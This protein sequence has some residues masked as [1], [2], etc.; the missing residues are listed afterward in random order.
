[1]NADIPIHNYMTGDNVTVQMTYITVNVYHKIRGGKG[2]WD[3]VEPGEM[4][5]V[6]KHIGK[7]LKL[8]V[9]SSIKFTLDD[10]TIKLLDLIKPEKNND[11]SRFNIDSSFLK[12]NELGGTDADFEMK[13]HTLS[14]KLEFRAEIHTQWGMYFQHSLCFGSHNSGRQRL[15][16]REVFEPTLPKVLVPFKAPS[17]SGKRMRSADYGDMGMP[18]KMSRMESQ[19]TFSDLRMQF[20]MKS[21]LSALIVCL[22]KGEEPFSWS[23]NSN[24]TMLSVLADQ[25]LLYYPMIV[26]TDHELTSIYYKD[27][28]PVILSNINLSLEI[29]EQILALSLDGINC[30]LPELTAMAHE[31]FNNIKFKVERARRFRSPP[32]MESVFDKPKEA[33]KITN[34]ENWTLGKLDIMKTYLSSR[35]IPERGN[36]QLAVGI[37][38]H[39]TTPPSAPIYI[40]IYRNEDMVSQKLVLMEEFN[41]IYVDHTES[42]YPVLYSVALFSTQKLPDIKG[43]V[44]LYDLRDQPNQTIILMKTYDVPEVSHLS[45]VGKFTVAGSNATWERNETLKSN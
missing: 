13:I 39:S 12:D 25:I 10:L 38:P 27:M 23:R 24:F 28:I 34:D 5:R 9:K 22:Q 42:E 8:S 37:L 18:S 3:L 41:V 16:K 2:I 44:S 21:F 11:E 31:E 17:E 20:P 43:L 6:T 33:P 1:M 29:P 32:I 40:L 45:M 15:G 7:R 4:I 26:R 30:S 19:M 14:K 35:V 36:D